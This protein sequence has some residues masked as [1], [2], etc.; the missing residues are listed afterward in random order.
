MPVIALVM[1]A[2]CSPGPEA[3]NRATATFTAQ[4]DLGAR[5]FQQYCVSCHSTIPETIIVGPSLAGIRERA[6][7]RVEGMTAREY[8]EMSVKR[9]D[10]FVVEGF[11]DLMPKSLEESLS[12][13]EMDAVLAYLMRLEK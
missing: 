10:A 5:V 7:E 13:E 8:M 11:A 6:A 12:E 1:L 2:G 4:E 3:G 9:P